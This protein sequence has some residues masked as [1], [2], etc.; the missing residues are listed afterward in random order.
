MKNRCLPVTA[1]PP[2]E[3]VT[4]TITKEKRGNC[5]GSRDE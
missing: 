3:T 2:G 5:Y 1:K 4:F